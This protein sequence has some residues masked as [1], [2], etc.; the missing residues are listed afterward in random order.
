MES[1]NIALTSDDIPNFGNSTQLCSST[2][3]FCQACTCMT[4]KMTF[5]FFFA[6]LYFMGVFLSQKHSEVVALLI[7]FSLCTYNNG[8]E[9]WLSSND[10]F[11][12][13]PSSQD[14]K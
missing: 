6:Y 14:L 2:D 11:L 5:K 12:V 3:L 1:S 8:G 7:L 10:M 9:M 13:G 4:W